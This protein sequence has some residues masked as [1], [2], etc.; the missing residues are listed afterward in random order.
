[1]PVLGSSVTISASFA[2][3]VTPTDPDGLTLK[4]LDPSGNSAIDTWPVATLDPTII[5]RDSA[6]EFH[7]TFTPDVV[8]IWRWRWE[9]TG[10]AGAVTEGQFEITSVFAPQTYATLDRAIALFETTPNATRQ[11][12]LATALRTATD[13]LIDEMDG[14]DFFRH[15]DVG[16]D[17]FVLTDTDGRWLHVHGGIV[18]ITKLELIT[19]TTY[20]ELTEGTDYR[21]RGV[22]P[23]QDPEP[24]GHDPAF[25]IEL[26]RRPTWH[27]GARLTGALGWGSIPEALAEGCAARARQLVYGSANYEGAIASD[28][29]YGHPTVSERWPDVTWK[30]MQRQKTNFYACLFEPVAR[31]M[32]VSW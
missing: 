3:D 7:R 15:P 13:E 28:D 14:R 26:L 2:V 17:E 25:H 20:T 27:D 31:P 9:G 21:L 4:V 29:G 16:D 11:A 24:G 5:V 12:R 30:W 22:A 1:M 10:D 8:G 32:A 6:G 18:S 19:G 23:T